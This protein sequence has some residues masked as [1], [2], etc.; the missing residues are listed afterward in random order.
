MA[1]LQHISTEDLESA[2]LE[3]S[4]EIT[5]DI[6]LETGLKMITQDKKKIIM[7]CSSIHCMDPS[8]KS[9]LLDHCNDF[10]IKLER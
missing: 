4:K 2:L 8:T 6:S 10:L 7:N 9:L 1:N 5:Q 3:R